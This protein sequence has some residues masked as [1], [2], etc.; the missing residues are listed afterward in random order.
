METTS[1]K[2]TW[3]GRS[4]EVPFLSNGR[5]EI[6]FFSPAFRFFLGLNQLPSHVTG[7]NPCIFHCHNQMKTTILYGFK[8]R[9][10]GGLSPFQIFFLVAE[11]GSRREGGVLGSRGRVGWGRG[12]MIIMNPRAATSKQAPWRRKKET[13][14]IITEAPP[15]PP[16]A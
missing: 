8:G 3:H 15:F 4:K 6:S 5:G 2:K 11:K 16:R 1:E 14:S 7:R 12:H 13:Q 10:S 9:P